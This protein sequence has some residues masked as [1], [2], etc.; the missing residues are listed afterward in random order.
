MGLIWRMHFVGVPRVGDE[1]L[2]KD[3]VS[4]RCQYNTPHVRCQRK[5]KHERYT[6]AIKQGFQ[7][8]DECGLRMR[9]VILEGITSF[10]SSIPW[11]IGRDVPYCAYLTKNMDTEGMT[12]RGTVRGMTK[13]GQP[14]HFNSVSTKALLQDSQTKVLACISP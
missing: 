5:K 14:L 9:K 4:C 11:F 6:I 12:R 2:A 1:L 8:R 3:T 13:G 10:S 7:N